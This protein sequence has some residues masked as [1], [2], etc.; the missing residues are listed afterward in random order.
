MDRRIVPVARKDLRRIVKRKRVATPRVKNVPTS[1]A[2]PATA[3]PDDI[4]QLLASLNDEAMLETPAPVTTSTQVNY[5]TYPENPPLPSL[6]QT[7]PPPPPPPPSQLQT[8]PTA[9]AKVQQ[10]RLL[11]RQAYKL[12]T[13][14]RV[15]VGLESEGGYDATIHLVNAQDHITLTFEDLLCLRG[16][17]VTSVVKR[18]MDGFELFQP[19]YLDTVLLE[20]L[21]S[22]G[23]IVLTNY[24]LQD[25][26][27]SPERRS[28]SLTLHFDAWASF[29]KTFDCVESYFR[30][31]EECSSVVQSLVCRYTDY[32]T[33]H[34]R[35]RMLITSPRPY[36]SPEV[37]QYVSMDL[38]QFLRELNEYRLPKRDSTPAQTIMS[39][40]LDAEVRRFCVT[41]IVD[42]V[43]DSIR[44]V[45]KR[46]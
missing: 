6:P 13:E 44:C 42:N 38:P 43:L 33:T 8:S 30:I 15:V 29:E 23:G 12:G 34:Y 40:W 26:L 16:S 1:A 39:P 32:L 17:A 25:D 37:I 46:K 35:R 14:A 11:I 20:P 2:A 45:K 3:P 4:E 21:V 7:L 18:C 28:S 19:L 22:G 41:S 36:L 31:C 5:Y 24:A 10:P 27:Y 9:S